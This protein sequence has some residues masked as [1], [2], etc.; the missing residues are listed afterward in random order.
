[1]NCPTCGKPMEPGWLILGKNCNLE[2]APGRQQ[3]P[4]P[5]KGRVKLLPTVPRDTPFDFPEYAAF[6][7]KD[8]KIALF[9]Y[10]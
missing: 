7:C 9:P 6:V 8:C 4:L 5:R 1:M 2:W 3:L 10:Q